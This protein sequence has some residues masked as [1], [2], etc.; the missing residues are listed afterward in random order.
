M[1][2]RDSRSKALWKQWFPGGGVS[3]DVQA[4]ENGDFRLTLILLKMF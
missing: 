1:A 2:P 3:D 4:V